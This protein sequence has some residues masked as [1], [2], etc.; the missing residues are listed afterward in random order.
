MTEDELQ[1]HTDRSRARSAAGYHWPHDHAYWEAACPA[2]GETRHD[3]ET[4]RRHRA[5]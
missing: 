5:G 1:R 3:C 2:C 4:K